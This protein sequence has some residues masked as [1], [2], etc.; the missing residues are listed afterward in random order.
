VTGTTRSREPA[1]LIAVA[2]VALGGIAGSFARYAISE[3][4][5]DG[6]LP[7]GTLAA[8]VLG[9]LLL[10]LLLGVLAGRRSAPWWYAL[11]GVGLLGAFTTMSTFQV[12]V[13]DM[14]DHRRFASAAVYVL[15]S[16]GLG[17]AAAAVGLRAS[18]RERL[19]G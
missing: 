4:L 19:A 6:R 11:A 3:A 8:N 17:L 15:L 9:S 10:G 12:Q 13:V 5:D 7:W 18:R 2:L 1:G 16:V 14:I